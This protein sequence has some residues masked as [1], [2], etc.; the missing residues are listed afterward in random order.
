MPLHRNGLC[1]GNVLK[2]VVV[3]RRLLVVTSQ[4]G[5]MRAVPQCRQRQRCLLFSVPFLTSFCP[6]CGYF[7]V[8][9]IYGRGIHNMEYLTDEIC[10]IFTRFLSSKSHS[11]HVE[12]PCPIL[13]T[14]QKVDTLVDSLLGGPGG[15]RPTFGRPVTARLQAQLDRRRSP[16]DPPLA[17]L[18]STFLKCRVPVSHLGSIQKALSLDRTLCLEGQEG[19]EPSTFCLRGRR[20]NQLSYWPGLLQYL[21][22]A[23]V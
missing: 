4:R 16:C 5:R 9:F 23:K 1:G 3:V 10:N 21:H 6:H 8:S 17:A 18:T 12:C 11:L 13:A 19:L 22:H 7:F 20:S 14:K 2:I 15:T